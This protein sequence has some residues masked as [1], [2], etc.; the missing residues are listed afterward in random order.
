MENQRNQNNNEQNFK[1]KDKIHLPPFPTW[2]FAVTLVSEIIYLIIS[3]TTKT[4]IIFLP[5]IWL[6]ISI[7]LIIVGRFSSTGNAYNELKEQ[8]K[9]NIRS[10][11]L[12][13]ISYGIILL[14][15]AIFTIFI[16]LYR[17]YT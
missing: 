8:T 16:Y 15:L 10:I 1:E 11:G 7:M 9:K 2:V 17:L 13:I 6:I 14:I 5:S 3:L 12:I 4:D